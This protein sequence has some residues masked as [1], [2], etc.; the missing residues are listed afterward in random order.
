MQA[1]CLGLDRS[2]GQAREVGVLFIGRMDSGNPRG[3]ILPCAHREAHRQSVIAHLE[4]VISN[5][6]LLYE[7]SIE[8]ERINIET[9]IARIDEIKDAIEAV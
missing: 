9:I 2:G 6:R 3:S 8:L 4:L 5:L 7:S 1:Q